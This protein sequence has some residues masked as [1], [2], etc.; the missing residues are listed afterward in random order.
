M[1]HYA[2]LIVVC[3]C[4]SILTAGCVS[5]WR[6]ELTDYREY[7]FQDA[8]CAPA[9]SSVCAIG[10]DWTIAEF[11]DLKTL[12]EKDSPEIDFKNVI[13]IEKTGEA[14]FVNERTYS[15]QVANI[16]RLDTRCDSWD[17]SIE[18]FDISLLSLERDIFIRSRSVS[19]IEPSIC[20]Q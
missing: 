13:S 19:L 6:S 14:I 4:F 1:K 7:R 12:I 20:V 18:I 5:S 16:R 15:V 17:G 11:E 9:I 2:P 3:F 8:G 10:E